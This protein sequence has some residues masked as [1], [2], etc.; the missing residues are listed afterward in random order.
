MPVMIKSVDNGR[1]K[2][3]NRLTLLSKNAAFSFRIWSAEA[4]RQNIPEM[5]ASANS[6]PHFFLELKRIT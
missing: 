4:G 6:N 3:I 1:A 2:L 5:V